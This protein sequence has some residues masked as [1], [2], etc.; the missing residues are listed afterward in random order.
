MI[1]NIEPLARAMAERICR[2]NGMFE[3]NIPGWVDLHW[4]CAAAM[5]EA[6]VMDEDGVDR[7]QGCPSRDRG[8]SREICAPRV[9]AAVAAASFSRI[10][11]S[12][13]GK[14]HAVDVRVI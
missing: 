13:R 5:L 9:K 4:Q 1:S 12:A 6:G 2:R 11:A 8:L 14:S 3:A 10:W 7:R